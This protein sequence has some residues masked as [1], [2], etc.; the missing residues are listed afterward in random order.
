MAN[1]DSDAV[2]GIIGLSTGESTNPLD[3]DR[4][5]NLANDFCGGVEV[6]EDSKYANVG[7]LQD[8]G[9]G[10]IPKGACAVAV[11]AVVVVVLVVFVEFVVV[12]DVG[13]CWVGVLGKST[14][15][16]KVNGVIEFVLLWWDSSIILLNNSRPCS[17]VLLFL[18]CC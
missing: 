18:C 16:D 4:L 13:V 3:P 15:G 2:R 10:G 8:C 12:M 1:D 9:D 6:N 17:L 14:L 11:A 5:R 7:E